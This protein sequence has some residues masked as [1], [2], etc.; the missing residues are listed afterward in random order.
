MGDAIRDAVSRLVHGGLAKQDEILG[1]SSAEIDEIEDSSPGVRLP[2]V[3]RAFLE[4]M[5]RSAGQFMRGTDLFYPEILGLRKIAEALLRECAV[6][7]RLERQH[8]VFCSHQGY[9]FLFFDCTRGEDPPVWLFLEGE[10][11]PRE[12]FPRFSEW[13]R[14]CVQDE[15]GES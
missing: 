9:Q 15:L 2:S 3:Y 5:G 7:W 6:A 11:A 4:S 1:C 10:T 8:F 12:V 14:R 13:L